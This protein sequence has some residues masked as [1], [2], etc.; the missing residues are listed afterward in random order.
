ML[1]RDLF[2]DPITELSR[3]GW[4]SL[5][6]RRDGLE[7]LHIFC[8]RGVVREEADPAAFLA[9]G[10]PDRDPVS[11]SAV[12]WAVREEALT[13]REIAARLSEWDCRGLGRLLARMVAESTLGVEGGR[14]R[15]PEPEL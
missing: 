9:A 10:A 1:Q 5:G 4:D 12:W 7:I 13:R 14:Y 2:S 11:E 3:L 8:R 6:T 15:A